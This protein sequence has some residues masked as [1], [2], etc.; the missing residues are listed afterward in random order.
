MRSI[1]ILR[2]YI[3][4]NV[5]DEFMKLDEPTQTWGVILSALRK[6]AMGE[7]RLASDIE[8]DLRQ[9]SVSP[10]SESADDTTPT[11]SPET[12]NIF[13]PM[14]TAMYPSETGISPKYRLD[15]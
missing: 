5:L 6:S 11:Y 7:A 9:A 10:D 14:G 15:T 8:K 1:E 2:S 13:R 3:L 4:F 12:S